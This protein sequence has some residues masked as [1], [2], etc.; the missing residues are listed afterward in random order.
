MLS[1]AVMSRVPFKSTTGS[2][3]PAPLVRAE[4]DRILASELFTRAPRLSSFLEFIVLSTLAGEGG[5]LKEHV[6]AIELYGKGADFDTAADPIVRVDARRLRDRLREY[7][8]STPPSGMVITI[9][10][11]SYTPAFHLPAVAIAAETTTDPRSNAG[12]QAAASPSAV[13]SRSAGRHP[14]GPWLAAAAVGIVVLGSAALVNRLGRDSLTEPPRLI[15]A[16]SRPGAEENPSLSPDGNFVAFSWGGAEPT[17]SHDIWI[18]AVDGDAVRQLTNTPEVMEKYPA[19]SPDGQFVAFTRYIKGAPSI[20]RVSALGGHEEVIENNA[21]E[22]DWTPDGKSIVF[23]TRT[24]E[25][26]SRLAQHVLETGT[27]RELTE[28]PE[29]FDDLHPAV[30][31]DGKRVAFQRSGGRRSAVLVLSLSRSSATG[32]AAPLAD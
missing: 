7:Y 18:K 14:A 2:I 15:T 27:R 5:S 9:P 16:T 32:A 21:A 24:E 26:R 29:G 6:I 10:K 19:W 30:S 28:A 25:G 20:V 31:P 23:V 8:A 1:T 11:G 17:A 22:A 4:L 12:L 3:P 13:G